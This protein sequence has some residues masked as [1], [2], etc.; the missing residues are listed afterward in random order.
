MLMYGPGL[1][2]I[3]CQGEYAKAGE[4]YERCQAIEEKV[5]GPEHPSFVTTLHGR[6]GLFKAQVR[7]GGDVKGISHLFAHGEDCSAQVPGGVVG[8]CRREP[9]DVLR[10]CDGV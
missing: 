10:Q 2:C 3:S 9:A 8:E 4:L 7:A 1:V 5:L 6:A